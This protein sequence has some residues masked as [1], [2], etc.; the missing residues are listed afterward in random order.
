MALNIKDDEI[1]NMAKELAELQGSSLTEAVRTALT[2]ELERRKSTSETERQAMFQALMEISERFS[3]LPDMPGAPPITPDK[4][5]SDH[6]W[7]YDENG[8]PI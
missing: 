2:H 4:P 5:A 1:H 3:A 7:L 6:S 8:L